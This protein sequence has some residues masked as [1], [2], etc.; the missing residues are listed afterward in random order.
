MERFVKTTVDGLSGVEKAAILLAEVGP[1][2]N[3]NYG[4]LFDS[5]NLSTGEMKKLR[6]AMK[7]LGPYSLEGESFEDGMSQ[8]MREQ[9]VLEEALAFGKR[10]GIVSFVPH[11]TVSQTDAV[12]SASQEIKRMAGQNPDG[13]ARILREW[14]GEH[15]E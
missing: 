2:D 6:V 15:G 10:R 5:L 8:I 3:P 14:L 11:S 1:L 4:A 7:K 12:K 13:M 9:A